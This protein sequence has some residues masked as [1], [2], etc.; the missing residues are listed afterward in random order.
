YDSWL[1]IPLI[2]VLLLLGD[3]DKVAAVTRSVCYGLLSIPFVAAWM[4]GNERAK[5]DPF[6]PIKYIESFHQAWVADGVARWTSLGS[7]AQDRRSWPR[8]ALFTLSPLVAWFGVRGMLQIW[9]TRRDY[10][11]LVWV[12]LAPTAYFTFRGVVLLNFVPLAR[13]AVTQVA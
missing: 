12:A 9:R 10:R 11:W 8:V 3:K 2:C 6:A 7:R 1:L 13:F 4:Q 5:G